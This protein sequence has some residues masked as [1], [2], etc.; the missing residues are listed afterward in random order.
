MAYMRRTQNFMASRGTKELA[1]G[2]LAGGGNLVSAATLLASPT[3]DAIAAHAAAPP[4]PA[5]PAVSEHSVALYP[6]GSIVHRLSSLRE[7]LLAARRQLCL[8]KSTLH[9]KP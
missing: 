3:A 4:P 6:S 8:M 9:R 5:L 2:A 1:G 7:T